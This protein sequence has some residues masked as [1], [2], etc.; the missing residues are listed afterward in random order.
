MN[1][2][3]RNI[4][5]IH[6]QIMIRRRILMKELNR[7]LCLVPVVV[8]GLSLTGCNEDKRAE[9]SAGLPVVQGA[10]ADGF[11]NHEEKNYSF[12]VM[13]V[14]DEYMSIVEDCVDVYD[15]K[16]NLKTD[17]E[18]GQIA[19]VKAD[20]IILN[21]GI[22]G[23]CNDISVKKVK[24]IKI[25]D[26][27]EVVKKVDIPVAGTDEFGYYKRFFQYEFYGDMY[28]IFLNRQ[29]IDVYCNGEPYMEY[30]FDG[31]DDDFR[32]F[33]DSLT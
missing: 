1:Q 24:S 18:D 12:Y 15:L 5:G 30:E 28:F 32:P 27:K 6:H 8:F 10:M 14:K 31:L 23:Y 20:V 29:Y 2:V 3:I 19:L 25:L 26:Y 7:L 21:G 13:K 16:E 17:L 11:D 33:F 4:K 22:A 9:Y